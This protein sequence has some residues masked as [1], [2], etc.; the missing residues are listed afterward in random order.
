MNIWSV[1]LNF[2]V[3]EVKTKKYC[4]T[5]ADGNILQLHVRGIWN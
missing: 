3:V 1:L 5:E 2:Y 4:N